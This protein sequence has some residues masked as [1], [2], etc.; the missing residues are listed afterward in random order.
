MICL[1]PCKP[2]SLRRQFDCLSCAK[3]QIDTENHRSDCSR[4]KPHGVLSLGI[5]RHDM[6]PIPILPWENWERMSHRQMNSKSPPTRLLITVF[7]RDAVCQKRP[8]EP[9]EESAKRIRQTDP[10]ERSKI[11]NDQATSDV[12]Q[13]QKSTLKHGPKFLSLTIS[14]QQWLSKIHHN[15][16]HPSA[17]K[18]QAVLKQQGYD[19]ALI[20]GLSDFRCSTRHELQEPRLARPAHL[21]E[22]REFNDCVGCDLVTWTAKTGRTYQFLHCIDVAT[23]FQTARP[24]FQTD[25]ESLFDVLKDH[26]FS[27]AGPCRQL[28]VDNGSAFCS[29]QFANLP[30]EWTFTFVW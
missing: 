4:P 9:H 7:D 30:K 5:Q 12:E 29:D 22:P 15:L 11:Y 20:Q 27:W 26:W 21:S 28:I 17:S 19:D 10:E 13:L 23:C 8:E 16:G 24:V 3:G 2:C 25:A 6:S 18:L 14:Q 1:S